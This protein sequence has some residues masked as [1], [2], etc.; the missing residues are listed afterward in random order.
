MSNR[1]VTSDDDNSGQS[2]RSSHPKDC[3]SGVPDNLLA[4]T[5][6]NVFENNAY[7]HL[8]E[9]LVGDRENTV[10]I[11]EHDADL[12]DYKAIS[13]E[14]KISAVE[15]RQA[16]TNDHRDLLQQ[17]NTQL[18]IAN[19]EAQQ[20]TEQIQL[21]QAELE[22]A[23]TVAEKAN[24]AKSEFLS[25]MSHELRTPLNAIL[26]F[27]QLLEVGSPPPTD[28]QTGRLHQII[29]AGWYLLDL[30]NEILDLALIESGKISL[31][32]E[33]V[34]LINV[35]H[36]CQ[37]MI[38][39]LAQQ[40]DIQL[41]FLPFDQTLS[42]YADR[43][44]V[45]QILINLFSNAVKYNREHGTVDVKCAQCSPERIRISI[46]DSGGGMSPEMLTQLFQPFNCLGQENGNEQGTGIGL[47][48]TK[49][50]VELMGGTMGV[51]STIEVGSEFWVELILDGTPQLTA[52][53]TKPAEL[54]WQAQ[55]NSP[56]R[57]LL[58][59]EDN[60]ANLLLVE[61]I[62]AGHDRLRM[63]NA[64]DGH[65]GIALARAQ[66]PAVILMDINLPGI[67]GIKALKILYED[68]ATGHIPIIALSA[69]ALPR[70]IKKGLE[71]GFFR[72][73]TKPIKVKELMKALD[74]ALNIS[75][76]ATLDKVIDTHES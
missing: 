28:V 38:E 49:Q 22:N 73:L 70:D 61:Q 16:A 45:K 8:R 6:P 67:N 5:S 24:Y 7:N 27:A 71:A 47:V 29:K 15:T 30:I 62:L 20:L 23:K 66:L 46:K 53:Y 74:D 26:G 50:L 32:N 60:P 69:N 55:D 3:S 33:P 39:S 42:V 12:R 18:V 44:R 63:I 9:K 75:E 43:I 35:I 65:L 1:D 58:Y 59:V 10:S 76:R 37:A 34:L 11:R 13:R 21:T 48:V 68:P 56:L 72:Y 64:H 2:S 4:P 52:G 40:R 36:E 17:A 54:V 51:E 57:T 25:S 14:L 31:S 41:N 19:L